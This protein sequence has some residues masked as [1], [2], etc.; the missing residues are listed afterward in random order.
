M[1]R[2]G[3]LAHRLVEELLLRLGQRVERPLLDA[4][5]LREVAHRRAVVALLREEPGGLAGQLVPASADTLN[6]NDRSAGRR[7]RGSARAGV[8][9]L[10][11]VRRARRDRRLDAGRVPQAADQ[12]H[13]DAR[14]LGADG[15]AARARLDPARADAAAEARADRE[16]PGRGR[17]LPADLPRRRGSRQAAQRLP[18]RPD[19]GQVEVPQRLP[20]P[21]E[22]LGRRRR[23][24][25]ARRRGRDHQPEGAPEVLVRAVRARDEEGLLGGVVPHP[26]RPRHDSRDGDRDAGA[27]RARAGGAQPLVGAADALPRHA[28]PGRGGS[29]GDLADQEPGERGRAAA[30][31]RG[32]RAA[33]PRARPRDPR[34]EAA[35]QRRGRLGV[36]RA[37]LGQAARRRH[38]PRAGV[39]GAARLPRGSRAPRRTGSRRWSSRRRR[40]LGG[41]QAGAEGAA[42]RARR[43]VPRARPG[44]RGRVRARVLRAAAGVGRALGRAAR[45]DHGDRGVPGRVRPQVPPRRRLLDQGEAEGGA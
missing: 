29:D 43:L 42:V 35:P 24:R 39:A 44:V 10:R 21:D 23:D 17:P 20:L 27:A 31:P 45:G 38:R 1:E 11:P 7:D 12:V 36:H 4:H 14:Q 25:L 16:D 41:L 40:D 30:V 18:R 3:A 28:D 22:E 2:R 8:S 19:L 13:R 5:R 32:L 6:A 33:D 37:R 15:R 34:P 26:P 9:R